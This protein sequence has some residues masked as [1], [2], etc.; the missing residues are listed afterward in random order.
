MAVIDA[1]EEAVLKQDAARQRPSRFPI[2]SPSLEIND[3]PSLAKNHFNPPTTFTTLYQRAYTLV[4]AK[5]GGKAAEVQRLVTF[6]GV[7]GSASALNL[8]CVWLFDHLLHPTGGVAI[9]LV[10]ATATEISLLA[11]FLL[12]DRFTFRTLVGD[13][14]TF[15]QRCRRFHG[16]AM[17]GFALT[18]LISNL[19]HHLAHLTLTASQAVAIV[20]VTVVNFLMHRHW[21]YRDARPARAV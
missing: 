1:Q 19:T 5:T 18:L 10:L 13:H 4:D 8:A 7:G 14:R 16:P 2:T 3:D 20:I 11:N 17:V 21:T 12:N 15:W 9:F 6:L